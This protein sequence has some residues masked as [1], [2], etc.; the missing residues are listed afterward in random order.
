MILWFV[1][2]TTTL[3]YYL[4]SWRKIKKISEG[5]SSNLM[6]LGYMPRRRNREI[7]TVK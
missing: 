4:F 1:K 7:T 5:V 2:C 3:E 6:D